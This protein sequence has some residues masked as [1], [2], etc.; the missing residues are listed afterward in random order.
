MA[1]RIQELKGQGVL[2]EN[3]DGSPNVTASINISERIK[4]ELYCKTLSATGEPPTPER[5]APL[6]TL[7]GELDADRSER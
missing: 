1:E 7:L 2:I 5:V 3:T 6:S 4:Q